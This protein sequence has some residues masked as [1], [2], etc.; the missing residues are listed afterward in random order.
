MEASVKAF[1]EAA[2]MGDFG[3]A[4]VEASGFFFPWKLPYLP[5]ELSCK[6]PLLP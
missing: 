1:V 5:W 2:S 3:K 4:S 6:L